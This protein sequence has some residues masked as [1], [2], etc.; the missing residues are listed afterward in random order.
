MQ[1]PSTPSASTRVPYKHHSTPP[2]T[3]IHDSKPLESY[4]GTPIHATYQP[5]GAGDV[6]AVGTSRRRLSPSPGRQKDRVSSKDFSQPRKPWRWSFPKSLRIVKRVLVWLI[7]LGVIL[8]VVKTSRLIGPER[9]EAEAE[10]DDFF[11][12][13]YN[14]E[15]D[16]GLCQFV[17]PVDAY[18]RD[19]WRL[20]GLD[21]AL[22]DTHRHNNTHKHSHSYPHSHH[23]YSSTGHFIVSSDPEASHPIP[24]LL[25]LG[26]K[27]WEELLSRQSLT[28]EDAVREYT[29]RYGRRPPK[30]FDIWWDFASVHNIVLPDEYDRINLDL[31]PFFALP[32][33]EMARRMKWVEEMKETF[34]LVIE[35]GRVEYQVSGC[36]HQLSVLIVPQILDNGGLEWEGTLPRARDAVSSASFSIATSQLILQAH[37]T[38]CAILAQHEGDI[39]NLRSAT[40]LYVVGAARVSD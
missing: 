8:S 15:E 39:L 29:R 21:P 30:G 13:L 33:K 24:L 38:L 28:L 20:R 32:K 27:R 11:L 25:T 4:F 1:P 36:W 22:F 14:K 6:D 26:E 9:R 7:A 16:G 35:D 5:P 34:T 19:L 18:H 23:L 12:P 31:A 2:S 40:D 17:S 3:P 37:K 10:A